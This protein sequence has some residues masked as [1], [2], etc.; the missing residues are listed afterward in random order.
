MSGVT[1]VS[2]CM[3]MLYPMDALAVRF[4]IMHAYVN[5]RNH[6]DAGAPVQSSKGV[7]KAFYI[8][9]LLFCHI[10]M[11]VTRFALPVLDDVVPEYVP[12]FVNDLNLCSIADQL[13]HGPS[14]SDIILEDMN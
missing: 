3:G 13:G 14:P 2:T 9:V 6:R 7:C 11:L 8:L 10:L 12:H 5:A 4:R 1:P